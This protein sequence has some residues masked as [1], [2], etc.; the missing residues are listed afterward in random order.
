MNP[1][2]ADFAERRTACYERLN[3]PTEAR[4]FVNAA[5]SELAAALREFD[6]G[7]AG[8]SGVRLDPRRRHPIIVSPLEPQPE[9]LG[10]AA[11]TVRPSLAGDGR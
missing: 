6:Q 8:N 3:L 5:R 1:L 2:P 7:L 11:I 10:L 9:P 4:D